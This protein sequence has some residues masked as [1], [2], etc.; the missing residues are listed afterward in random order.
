MVFY[1]EITKNIQFFTRK[2]WKNNFC[3]SFPFYILYVFL[4]SENLV[5][6]YEQLLILTDI[7]GPTLRPV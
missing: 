2:F 4:V 1:F 3:A 7:D 6:K 5:S